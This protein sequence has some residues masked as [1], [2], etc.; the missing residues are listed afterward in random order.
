ME[1]SIDHGGVL[2]TQAQGELTL[3]F[4]KEFLGLE[5]HIGR[6]KGEFKCAYDLEWV[7]SPSEQQTHYGLDMGSSSVS[8][9]SQLFD[10][11]LSSLSIANNDEDEFY[12][13]AD[14][15]APEQQM[16]E[17]TEEQFLKSKVVEKAVMG[18]GAEVIE[19]DAEGL[20]ILPQRY[21]KVRH[22]IVPA[23]VEE[24]RTKHPYPNLMLKNDFVEDSSGGMKL[25]NEVKAAAQNNV[26][27]FIM[28]TI[29]KNIF[30]GKGILNI[31]LPV[32]IFNCDSNI[33]RLCESFSMGP[34]LLEKRACA[35]GVDAVARFKACV[36]FAFTASVLYFDI[37]KAFNPILGETFQGFIDGCPVY[38]EQTSHHPPISSIL[39]VGRGYRVYANI[40]AKVYVH[41][42]SG[43]GV[44]EGFCTIEFDDGGK[45]VFQTAP[46]EVSGLAVGDRKFRF[47]GKT[48]VMDAKN[49]LFC[50]IDFEDESG[51][52]SKK[53]WKFEDQIDGEIVRVSEGFVRNF[54][55]SKSGK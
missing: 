4:L 40:E 18:Y 55:E 31:S 34:D 44:N 48:F 23:K 21:L 39:L 6:F 28:G 19:L 7:V 27:K 38:G 43:E 1:I 54:F 46:G 16:F 36:A 25:C 20:V 33:Q 52:F 50:S 2:Q 49:R 8:L 3:R 12:S 13:I 35:P 41:L 47:K 15:D 11:P 53:K 51:L 45:V 17:L 5:S 29:K 32:E 9:T 10:Q 37:D 30:S 24:R 22:A 14:D 42:N 26:I